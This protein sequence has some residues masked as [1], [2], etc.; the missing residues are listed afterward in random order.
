MPTPTTNPSVDNSPEARLARLQSQ[1]R[2]N[3]LVAQN[4]GK[5]VSSGTAPVTTTPQ[6]LTYVNNPDG[7]PVTPQPN[8]PTNVVAPNPIVPITSTWQKPIGTMSTSAAG[9]LTTASDAASDQTIKADQS[10]VTTSTAEIKSQQ[11]ITTELGKVDANQLD[12]KVADA[13]ANQAEAQAIQENQMVQKNQNEIEYQKQIQQDADNNV[14]ALKVAQDSENTANAAAAAEMKAKNDAAEWETKASNEVA[15]QQSNIAFAKLGLSFSGAAINTAQNIYTSGVYNLAKLKTSNAKNYADLQVK[16]SSVQFDHTMAVNKII[17]DAHEKEFSSKER[18]R[19]FIG[20][21]QT[22]ILNS[23]EDSQKKI[24]DAI[25]VYKKEKQWRED[26]LFSDMQRANDDVISA[27]KD[28]QKTVSTEETNAKTKIDM[29]INNGQWGSLSRQQ[30]VD[31]E[32]RA[33]V[34]AGTS[35]NTIVAKTTLALSDGIKAIVGKAIALPPAILAK[36]H[37]EVQRSLALNIPMATAVKLA[38]DKYSNQIPEVQAAKNAASAKAALDASKVN[39]NNAT[40]TNKLTTAQAAL[41]KAQKAKTW[42]SWGSGGGAKAPAPNLLY[43]W[44]QTVNWKDYDVFAD[45]SWNITRKP[46][47][48]EGSDTSW[49]KKIWSNTDSSSSLPMTTPPAK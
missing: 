41:I 3:S 16:I 14:A 32:A 10:K 47:V 1:G 11:D 5:Q 24:Q 17:T 30:Q 15:L 45:K 7:S 48:A 2:G 22:N 27:T 39:L 33:W 49:T 28:I 26:K 42:G 34:P 31:L 8:A 25:D 43:K 35:A 9:N 12:T 37:T 40:A 36:M 19:D 23:K 18:L 13:K 44:T 4:L 21:A 20:K 29:L 38:L 6:P 46:V